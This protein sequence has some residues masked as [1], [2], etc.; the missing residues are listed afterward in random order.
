MSAVAKGYAL[1]NIP[2]KSESEQN[3]ILDTI[4]ALVG[5]QGYVRTGLKWSTGTQVNWARYD[6]FLAR[7]KARNLRWFPHFNT[8]VSGGGQYAI[9]TKNEWG[10]TIA[11]AVKRYM[12]QGV[13]KFEIWNEPDTRTG[14]C[15]GKMTPQV[16]SWIL[17][18][19]KDAARGVEI[20]MGRKDLRLTCFALGGIDL[21][22]LN[23]LYSV[24]QKFLDGYNAFSFHLYM[25]QDPSLPG[26]TK[27]I[28]RLRTIPLLRQWLDD[29]KYPKI[30]LKITEGGY[31]GS[32]DAKRPLNCVTEAEQ[33]KWTRAQYDYLAAHPELK[34]NLLC[35]YNPIDKGTRQATGAQYDYPYWYENLGA[36]NANGTKKPV[37]TVIAGMS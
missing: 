32:N 21:A 31:S 14:N 23:R 28:R 19:A 33:A 22:Y 2:D 9:P 30:N 26:G 34:L 8:S 1:G 12:E 15:G 36:V 7:C 4:A 3:K 27:Y 25:S 29:R 20:A 17:R 18:E 5:P 11:Q 35:Q 10:P 13:T 37:F 24:D 16:L 6:A